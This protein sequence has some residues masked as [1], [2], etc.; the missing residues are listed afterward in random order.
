MKRILITKFFG[1]NKIAVVKKENLPGIASGMLFII[2]PYEDLNFDLFEYFTTGTGS[3]IFSE[4]LD[5]ITGGETIAS[6]NKSNLSSLPIPT[7][8]KDKKN[9]FEN[10]YKSSF[11]SVQDIANQILSNL[12]GIKLEESVYESLKKVGWEDSDISREQRFK[13]E[14]KC[15]I[16]DFTLYSDGNPFAYVEVKNQ[17][18]AELAIKLAEEKGV[19]VIGAT[20][21]CFY[22]ESITKY[23]KNYIE[24]KG[25]IF[26]QHTNSCP[27]D[28]SVSLGQA[29]VA[30]INYMDK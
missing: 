16:P 13:Y 5:S 2:R 20:G 23:I 6:I 7:V 17:N 29:I 14:N 21:G 27:G 4:Q 1:Q 25:Y 10:A 9:S 18:L 3:K 28:G 22:N 11:E 30:G 15:L 26:L 24:D 8:T 12:K 19:K